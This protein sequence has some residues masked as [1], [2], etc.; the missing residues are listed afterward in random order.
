MI[1]EVVYCSDCK[2]PIKSVPSWLAD[3]NVRFSCESCRQKHP[4][5]VVGFDGAPSVRVAGA[6]LDGEEVLADPGELVVEE[7][8]LDDPDIESD[9]PLAVTED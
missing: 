8:V 1:Y 5:G 6:E 7:E 3:V 2:K 9:E 4:R